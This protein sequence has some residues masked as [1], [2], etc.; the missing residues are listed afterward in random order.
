MNPSLNTLSE[1]FAK[2]NLSA[3]SVVVLAKSIREHTGWNLFVC[4]SIASALK[5][6]YRL[7]E[8]RGKTINKK[9]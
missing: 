8:I 5:E 1:V 9:L 4:A 6:A 2:M 7:G 3:V